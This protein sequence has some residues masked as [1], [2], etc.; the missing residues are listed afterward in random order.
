M[1]DQSVFYV[2]AICSLVYG[3]LNY[4]KTWIKYKLYLKINHELEYNKLFNGIESLRG[5]EYFH[6]V[7][8]KEREMTQELLDTRQAYYFVFIVFSS[9]VFASIMFVYI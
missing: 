8:S 1:H 4:R 5:P 6:Y 2:Y 3:I 7:F 9:I